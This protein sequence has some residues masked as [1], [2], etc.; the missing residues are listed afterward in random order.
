MR[1]RPAGA[2]GEGVLG[3]GGGGRRGVGGGR[4]REFG[5]AKKTRGQR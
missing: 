4:A 2:E 3:E 1:G 5:F